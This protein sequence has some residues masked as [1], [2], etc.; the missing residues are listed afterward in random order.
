MKGWKSL[1][2]I[3]AAIF[4]AAAGAG[5]ASASTGMASFL[6]HSNHWAGYVA[7]PKAGGIASN[8]KDSQAVFTV[9]AM[10]CTVTPNSQ[11]YHYAGI[12]GWKQIALQAAGVVEGCSSGTP[13]YYGA[14]WEYSGNCACESG[15]ISVLA[16]NPGDTISAS[17]YY[18]SGFN[19]V[20]FK[21]ADQTTGT[22]YQQPFN[23]VNYGFYPSAEVVS[24]GNIANQ[25]TADFSKVSFTQAQV[26]DTSQSYRQA[27]QSTAFKTIAVE[28]IGPVTGLPDLA[29]GPL[30][31]TG[32]GKGSS[33]SFSNTWLRAN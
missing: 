9:P 23:N 20:V 27:L 17:A 1:A 19:W 14:I 26:I 11:A 31:S 30:S 21:V 33:S 16:I 4:A 25:G 22:Y 5:T 29:P 18:N 13:F 2:A 7:V 32:A 24:Y 12:G 6:Q 15:P 3:G 28:Q 8:F 10:N